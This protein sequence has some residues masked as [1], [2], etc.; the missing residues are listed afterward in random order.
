MR[1]SD[2]DVRL[3]TA[4]GLG[5]IALALFFLPLLINIVRG[6]SEGVGYDPRTQGS[7][8]LFA[9]TYERSVSQGP[10]N[11]RLVV[12]VSRDPPIWPRDPDPG[13]NW[14][15]LFWRDV[16][17]WSPGRPVEVTD[18]AGGI[19]LPS[20]AHIPPGY[21]WVQGVF[22]ASDSP[23]QAPPSGWNPEPG[24]LIGRP[25]E[26]YVDPRGEDVI[27]VDLARRVAEPEP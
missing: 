7:A 21:Y 26:V 11:G 15:Y 18:E 3:R 23:A 25:A 12:I 17:A 9:V 20:L 5:G 1:M 10:L 16:R 2:R 22:Q 6:G 13:T 27:R 14:P 8:M 19:P 24:D 4:L